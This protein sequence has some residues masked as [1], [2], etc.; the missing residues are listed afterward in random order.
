MIYPP[1][2]TIQLAQCVKILSEY[3]KH[4]HHAVI[5]ILRQFSG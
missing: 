3:I 1:Q 2:N 4:L 5:L